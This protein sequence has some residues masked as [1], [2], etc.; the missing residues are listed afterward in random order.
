M[1]RFCSLFLSL[2]PGLI[3]SVIFLYLATRL[4]F[5][6]RYTITFISRVEK[7]RH[8]SLKIYS[9]RLVLQHSTTDQYESTLRIVTRH[10]R[11]D[12]SIWAID[13]R[14]NSVYRPWVITRSYFDKDRSNIICNASFVLT[15]RRIDWKEE[16]KTSSWE[17]IKFK[18]TKIW[19]WWKECIIHVINM[20]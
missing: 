7:P 13:L 15:S 19:F 10:S 8:R 5:P 17:R 14:E 16:P 12:R 20:R 9:R 18:E 2:F 6:L 3:S 4:F 11:E 1:R